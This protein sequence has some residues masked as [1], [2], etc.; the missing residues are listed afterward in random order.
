[1]VSNILPLNP[2]TLVKRSKFNLFSEYG[3]VAY[4]IKENDACSNM[5]VNNLPSDYPDPGVWLNSS[6]SVLGRV[7]YQIKWNHEYSNMQAY[8]LPLH[9]PSTTGVGSNVKIF[10]PESSHIAYQIKRNRA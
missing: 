5:V 1:M 10:F 6:F 4:Q 7:A 8:I 9:A 3:H 2:P